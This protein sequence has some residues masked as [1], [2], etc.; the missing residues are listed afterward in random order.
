MRSK[1][2]EAEIEKIYKSIWKK[3][4]SK[5]RIDAAMKGKTNIIRSSI[6]NIETSEQFDEFAQKFAKKLAQKGLSRQRGLWRKYFKAAKDSGIIALPNTYSDFE[7][8][9][10]KNAITHNFKMIKSIPS[11]ILEVYKHQYTKTLIKQVAEGKLGR[12]SFFRQLSSHGH[13]NAKLI[14]RTETAKL[15]TS[16]TQNR[17]TEL[18]STAYIWQ[19]S[20]DIR[21]RQSHRAMNGVIVF[22]RDDEEEKP[23]LD[24]MYGH[25]GEFP[26]CRCTPLPI[27]DKTDL[28]VAMYK[29]Y[30]YKTHKIE[31]KRK[32]EVI[33]LL[34]N[35][36]FE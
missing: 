23:L 16:I 30:N 7:R 17:A 34:E 2:I 12:N 24:N 9:M 10:M 15:Q 4:F 25:A 35:G 27:F 33:K 29:V 1:Q 20:N 11:K 13:K 36:G 31:T 26:N 19:S 8:K 21:T 28:N 14:A 18:G 3:V 6:I 5:N 32:Q 22:W